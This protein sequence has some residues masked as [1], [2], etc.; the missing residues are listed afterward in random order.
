MIYIGKA[1]RLRSNTLVRTYSSAATYSL[2]IGT[3]LVFS[4]SRYCR[5]ASHPSEPFKPWLPSAIE[6]VTTRISFIPSRQKTPQQ[7]FR[8][9]TCQSFTD[10]GVFSSIPH[11]EVNRVLPAGSPVFTIV[12]EGRLADFLALL[13]DGYA[14]VR[15]HDEY[16]ASL[17]H[18]GIPRVDSSRT[19]LTC[20]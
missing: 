19:S 4:S 17:L 10:N 6:E 20:Q 9:T 18:V 12:K 11:L 15:D 2:E 5:E 16:G 8:I 1:K 13:K 14:S 3:L 7:M